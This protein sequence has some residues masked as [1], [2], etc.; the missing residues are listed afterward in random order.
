MV[1]DTLHFAGGLGFVLRAGQIRPSV[2]IGS[3]TLRRFFGAAALPK[4][5][6]AEMDPATP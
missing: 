2:A 5:Q 3:P 1:K 6:V 4:R